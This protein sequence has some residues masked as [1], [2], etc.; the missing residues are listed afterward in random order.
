[1]PNCGAC[2][3]LDTLEAVLRWQGGEQDWLYHNSELSTQTTPNRS[4]PRDAHLLNRS[5]RVLMPRLILNRSNSILEAFNGYVR[6]LGGFERR[7]TATYARIPQYLHTAIF[8][9]GSH[10][11]R[12]SATAPMRPLAERHMLHYSHQTHN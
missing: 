11:H 9:C 4:N 1:M 7:K 12:H 10:S 2:P 3:V 8:N 5:Y 6:C